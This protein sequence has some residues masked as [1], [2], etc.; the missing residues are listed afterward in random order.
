MDT[1]RL[2]Q[3]NPNDKIDFFLSHDW[4]LDI[5]FKHPNY[6][7]AGL[8]PRHIESIENFDSRKP[9]VGSGKSAKNKPFGSPANAEILEYLKPRNWCAA[10]MHVKFFATVDHGDSKTEYIAL[11][12]V[13]D[14]RKSGLRKTDY[15]HHVQ[16]NKQNLESVSYYDSFD[17]VND[18]KLFYD[19][20]WLAVVRKTHEYY[21]CDGEI[22]F[23]P[24]NQ[25]F[26]ASDEDI[27]ITEKMLGDDLEIKPEYFVKS[28]DHKFTTKYDN[29]QTGKL[30]ERIQLEK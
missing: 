2:K 16:V 7:K 20:E 11:S 15:L 14:A 26:R 5:A 28:E 24:K 8:S 4:V 25:C 30:Y 19:L 6:K 17:T 1:W 3:L 9:I 23:L 22:P 10:H 18:Y 21:K 27:L 12:K 13:P 29:P